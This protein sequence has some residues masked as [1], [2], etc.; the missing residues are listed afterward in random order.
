VG[1]V[2]KRVS[3]YVKQSLCCMGVTVWQ[4][5]TETEVYCRTKTSIT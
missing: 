5:E 3:H 2:K 4:T 1:K